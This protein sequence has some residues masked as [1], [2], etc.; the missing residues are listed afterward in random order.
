MP[1]FCAV[2]VGTV[3]GEDVVVDYVEG[4]KDEFLVEEGID[5]DLGGYDEQDAANTVCYTPEEVDEAFCVAEPGEESFF[6]EKG[7]C[8]GS[9]EWPAYAC[10]CS[11]AE[12]SLSGSKTSTPVHK[13]SNAEEGCVHGEAAGEVGGAGMVH[14][15]RGE[16]DDEIEDCHSWV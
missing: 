14:S 5:S 2:E 6:G 16:G 11:E 13:G 4:D 3:G 7:D 10:S 9:G 15:G 8:E 12:D 1:G